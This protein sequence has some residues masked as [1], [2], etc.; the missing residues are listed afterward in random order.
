MKQLLGGQ[1]FDIV[2]TKFTSYFFILFL[3]QASLLCNYEK[4]TKK[5][6]S[7]LTSSVLTCRATGVLLFFLPPLPCSK[8]RFLITERGTLCIFLCV[9]GGTLCIFS[10]FAV[11]TRSRSGTDFPCPIPLAFYRFC[12]YPCKSLPF[13]TD[14]LLFPRSTTVLGE[15]SAFGCNLTKKSFARIKNFN[16]ST[17][18]CKTERMGVMQMKWKKTR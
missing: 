5:R 14:Y 11:F 18:K 17:I 7:L 15:F 8:G 12:A 2:L 6:I 16:Y 3:S 10:L 13:H 9:S 4:G 1:Y